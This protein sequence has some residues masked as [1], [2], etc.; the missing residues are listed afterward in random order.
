[1]AETGLVLIGG[2]MLSKSLIQFSVLGRGCVPSL[3]FDL[4]PNYAEGNE[5]NDDHL[6]NVP[7]RHCYSMPPTLQQVTT[8]PHLCQRLLDTHGQVCVHLLWG[9]CSFLLGPGAYKVLF[10]P[11]TSLFPQSCV[12]SAGSMVG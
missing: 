2:A 7:C 10:V 3:L 1:M 9:H 8:D 12:S 11:S 5:D 4:R 6:Q